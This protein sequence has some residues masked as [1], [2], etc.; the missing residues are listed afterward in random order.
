MAGRIRDEDIALVRERS[1]IAEVVGERVQLRNAGGGELKGLCPFHDEKSP[2][3]HVAPSRGYYHCFGCA[4]GG[5]VITF[6]QKV[7]HLSF[8]EAVEHLA[9]RAGVE[10]RYEEGT[11]GVGRDR[12]QRTR[13]VAAHAA[14]VEFYSGQ[15]SS[16]EA[17]A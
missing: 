14:A 7:E 5:D 10:L 8:S 3:F 15:L 17:I 6:L 1:A 12:G 11:A 13:L 2:S 9:Q 4:A 16:A